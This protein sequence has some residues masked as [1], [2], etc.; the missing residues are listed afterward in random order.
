[1]REK[2][3]DFM[4][5]ETARAVRDSGPLAGNV[6]LSVDAGV[7]AAAAAADLARWLDEEDGLRGCVRREVG[8]VPEGALGG[9]LEHLVVTLGSGGV[10]TAMASV[11]VAWLRRRTG[12]V[13]VR[14][15][16]R[17]GSRIELRADRVRALDA[18][19]LR[20]QV[21]QLAEAAWPDAAERDA[22]GDGARDDAPER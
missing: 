15:S 20:A 11:L 21:A 19:Q 16:R 13:T 17:D 1:M 4:A 3:G 2:R 12:S 6:T 5:G 10:A 22:H 9:E 14:L 7:P 18:A 8:P